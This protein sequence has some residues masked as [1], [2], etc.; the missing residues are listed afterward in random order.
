[1]PHTKSSSKHP[2]MALLFRSTSLAISSAGTVPARF[3]EAIKWVSMLTGCPSPMGAAG[4]LGM[5]DWFKVQWVHARTVLAEVVEFSPRWNRANE[6]LI[7]P[8][9]GRVHRLLV[10][11]FKLPISMSAT[12]GGPYPARRIIPEWAIFINFGPKALLRSLVRMLPHAGIL[13]KAWCNHTT[14]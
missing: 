12:G 4:V 3:T 6:A 14:R 13:H 11:S 5:R 8:S 1:M 9:M 10:F 7:C 2:A